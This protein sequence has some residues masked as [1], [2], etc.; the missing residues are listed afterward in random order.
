MWRKNRMRYNETLGF[1]RQYNMHCTGVD[2]NRNFDFEWG[3][4]K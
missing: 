1:S 4:G 2:N 3:T